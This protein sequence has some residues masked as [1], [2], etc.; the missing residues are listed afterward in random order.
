MKLWLIW[1]ISSQKTRTLWIIYD[2]PDLHRNADCGAC[3]EQM[4]LSASVTLPNQANLLV[5][6]RRKVSSQDKGLAQEK[7]EIRL[8]SRASTRKAIY[9]RHNRVTFQNPGWG[10]GCICASK[11]LRTAASP[12]TFQTSNPYLA[13][14]ACVTSGQLWTRFGSGDCDLL[15]QNQGPLPAIAYRYVMFTTVSLWA[16]SK[17]LLLAPYIA[18]EGGSW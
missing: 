12:G 11:T 2:S 14:G 16:H 6:G 9:W 7:E 15:P 13:S 5:W 10:L 4:K 8:H 18:F 1:P 17:L 3:Q